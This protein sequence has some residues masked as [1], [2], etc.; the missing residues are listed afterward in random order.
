MGGRRA[1]VSRSVAV[2]DREDKR[3][4]VPGQ[5]SGDP[6]QAGVSLGCVC[7]CVRVCEALGKRT[8][9]VQ[10]LGAWATV[11]VLGE[12]VLGGGGVDS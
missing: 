3:P 1:G 2:G 7:G 11:C 6:R 5:P 4:V 9:G 12:A 8:P 10:G